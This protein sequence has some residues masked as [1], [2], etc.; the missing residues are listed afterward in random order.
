MSAYIDFLKTKKIET[1]SCGIVDSERI[2]INE[3]LFGFQ[4]HIVEKALKSGKY[5]IF[6]DCGLGKSFMQIEWAK[7]VR[8]STSRPVLILCP[9]AVS[10]QTI[11]EAQKLGVEIEL[12]AGSYENKIYIT[13]YEQLDNLDCSKFSGVVLDESSILKN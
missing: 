2:E 8:N 6:A 7:N 11:L 10:F 9:L 4:K 12:F 5:A 13:N 3:K 1:V